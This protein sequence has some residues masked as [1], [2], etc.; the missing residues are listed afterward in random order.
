[1]NPISLSKKITSVYLVLSLLF[2]AFPVS[3]NTVAEL[4]AQISD[5][6]SRNQ[7][8]QSELQ[9]LNSELS[10]LNTQ[11]K[12]LG[13]AVSEL[14]ATRRKILTEIK[15]TEDKISTTESYINILEI[16]IGNKE[17][18]INKARKAIVS[19]IQKMNELESQSVAYKILSKNNFSD[20]VNETNEIIEF[21]KNLRERIYELKNIQQDLSQTIAQKEDEKNNLMLFRSEARDKKVVVEKNQQ[22]KATLLKQTQNQES[23]YQKMIAEKEKLRA[24]FEEELAA[25]ESQLQFILDPKSIPAPKHGVLAWP[26]DSIIITQGFGLTAD[27]AKLYSHRQGAWNGKHTGVDFRGNNDPVRAMAGGEVIGFGNTDTVCPRA[28]FGG[29][30]L[31][32]YD[33]GLASIYSHLQTITAKVG[34]RVKTGDVVAYSGNTGYSTGPHLD[35]K[36]VPASAVTIETWPSAGCPGKNYTTPIVAGATYLDPLSYLPKTTDDMWK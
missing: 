17:T 22:E 15:I 24:Q 9:K 20:A 10:K 12:T 8:L 14:D 27:S 26:L 13:N 11:S 23:E 7:A 35:V 28:S 5:V 36:V 21:Q 29:W 19:G 1:M 4:E 18:S 16:E 2:F 6:R 31:I 30:V 3:A 32:K 25:Y 33:N 34:Q